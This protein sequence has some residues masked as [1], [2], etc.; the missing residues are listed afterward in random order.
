MG[1]GGIGV[2]NG[3]DGTS[4]PVRTSVKMGEAA[5]AL[6]S[7]PVCCLTG[8]PGAILDLLPCTA[9]QNFSSCCRSLCALLSI[10]LFLPK[11]G[12][13]I[14]HMIGAHEGA[15]YRGLVYVGR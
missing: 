5:L 7:V 6:A 10:P 14:S 2:E 3:G 8:V 11:V 1:W 9:H 13:H 15:H 4:S 12:F